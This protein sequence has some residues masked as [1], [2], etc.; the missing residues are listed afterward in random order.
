MREDTM[1]KK[2]YSWII[3][4]GIVLLLFLLFGFTCVWVAFGSPANVMNAVGAQRMRVERLTKDVLIL[5]NH[6]TVSTR[7]QAV[8]EVQDT[9]PVW[10]E[11]QTGL[12]VGDSAL[13]LPKRPYADVVTLV[14][15]AGVDYVP[16][17]VALQKIEAHPAQIDPIQVQIV[18]SHENGYLTTM[19]NVN[20]LWQDHID[21]VFSQL[22][23]IETC[24]IVAILVMVIFKFW[25]L[26][27]RKTK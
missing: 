14:I 22:F 23:W 10:Q 13:G 24:L 6:P 25:Y 18:L 12:Q 16:L 1:Q 19:S 26:Y 20:R 5:A 21:G 3:F 11:T 8:S 4:I 27:P 7:A 17:A 2:R 15:G 9:L